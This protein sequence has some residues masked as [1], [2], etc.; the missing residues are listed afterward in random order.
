MDLSE[1]LRKENLQKQIEYYE[2]LLLQHGEKPEALDWNSKPSQLLR[3]KVMKNVFNYISKRGLDI[4]DVG[5]GFGDFWEYLKKEK[6]DQQYKVKYKGIDISEKLIEVA[7]KKHPKS[8]FEVKNILKDD[9]NRSF[10][11]VFCSGAFNIRFMDAD[12]HLKYV[13][14]L[15]LKM[16]ELS[17]IGVVANFLSAS[18]VYMTAEEDFNSNRY[19]YFRAEDI[20][21]LCR[22]L[23]SK[24]VLR[25]DYHAGDFTIYLFKGA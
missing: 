10:D 21:N 15:L 24:Y 9:F 2:N 16:F 25:H 18:A 3:Y 20:I 22:F 4:L 6:I 13:K 19:F 12:A 1:G 7:R 11:L 23:S 17:K 5:C 14:D 8:D